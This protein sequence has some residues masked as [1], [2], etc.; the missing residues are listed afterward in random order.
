M[1]WMIF[2]NYYIREGIFV[3]LLPILEY[4]NKGGGGGVENMNGKLCKSKKKHE[5]STLTETLLP[6]DLDSVH[7]DVFLKMFPKA[8]WMCPRGENGYFRKSRFVIHPQYIPC[9][10]TFFKPQLYRGRSSCSLYR[11]IGTL[12]LV[13]QRATD[14]RLGLCPFKFDG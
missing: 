9:C 10:I 4:F 14:T 8:N 1:Y 7:Q 12:I 2:L 11:N 13:W 5:H 3:F 6:H